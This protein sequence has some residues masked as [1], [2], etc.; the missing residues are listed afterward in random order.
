VVV[1]N[2]SYV[3]QATDGSKAITRA[4]MR[5]FKRVWADHADPAD[6][7]LHQTSLVAFLGVYTLVFS[8]FFKQG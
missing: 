4:Q 1:D 7:K 8:P 5:N 2:F 3:F 6:G